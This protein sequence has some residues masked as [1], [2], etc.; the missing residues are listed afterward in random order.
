[1]NAE[2]VD[3]MLRGYKGNKA[4]SEHLRLEIERVEQNLLIE[5]N[6]AI[7]N[8]AIHAQQ[9]SDMPHG[10]EVGR[11]VEDLVMKYAGGYVPPLVMGLQNEL[12]AMRREYDLCI[13]CV[14]YVDAW[15]QALN[16][17]EREVVTLQLIEGLYWSDVLYQLSKKYGLVF[18]KG[19]VRN[20]RNRAM[21]KIC[22]AAS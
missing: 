19:G 12:I 3:T 10:S 14:R 15:M 2:L 22:Q 8:D 6:N 11:P 5:S 1:M 20:I 18:S 4:R 17:R 21:E 7:A 16:E 13:G 9:Y